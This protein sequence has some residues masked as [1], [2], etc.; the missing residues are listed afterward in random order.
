MLFHLLKFMM[1][2]SHGS[3]Y[4]KRRH[5]C[6]VLPFSH[7]ACAF[8]LRG[9]GALFCHYHDSTRKKNTS[10]WFPAF[11]FA[12][13]A[14]QSLSSCTLNMLNVELAQQ[15]LLVQL[16]LCWALAVTRRHPWRQYTL[17]TSCQ[18]STGTKSL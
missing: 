2:V 4:P 13:R 10:K 12:F 14:E 9:S 17:S 3:Q 7:Q 6:I 1:W 5:F 11:T 8:A 18:K 15:Y 16:S